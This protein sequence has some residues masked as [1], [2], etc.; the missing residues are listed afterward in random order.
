[1]PEGLMKV[2][3]VSLVLS[4]SF[5]ACYEPIDGCL[6][7]I[8]VNYDL[9]AD[10]QC[11]SCCTYPKIGI[12][13]NHWW[14]DETLSTD[15]FYINGMRQSFRIIDVAFLVHDFEL[16]QSGIVLSTSDSIDI[17]CG[18]SSEYISDSYR[19]LSLQQRNASLSEFRSSGAYDQFNF[20][21]GMSDCV[22]SAELSLLDEDSETYSILNDSQ[23]DNGSYTSIS[24]KLVPATTEDTLIIDFRDASSIAIQ[25]QSPL[26]H[27]RGDNLIVPI[28]VDYSVW[29]SGIRLDMTTE[30]LK[31]T[32]LRD[33]KSSFSMLE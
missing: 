4:V 20:S 30:D 12:N 32:I 13:I 1:M 16:T 28:V 18:I 31:Q 24:F 14:G 8:S 7:P 5:S 10:D 11:E 2:C 22:Q 21:L 33:T 26:G 3:L 6:D 29:L 25:L 27:D 15:S 17:T 9:T 23:N 19:E